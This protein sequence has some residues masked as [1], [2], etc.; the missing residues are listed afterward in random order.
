ML[1]A[2][3]QPGPCPTPADRYRN[4]ARDLLSGKVRALR[5]LDDGP[6]F[7]VVTPGDDVTAYANHGGVHVGD[8]FGEAQ[9]DHLLYNAI[10]LALSRNEGPQR[11]VIPTGRHRLTHMLSEADGIRSGISF[12]GCDPHAAQVFF[13]GTKPNGD[14]QHNGQMFYLE[15]GGL[16]NVWWRNLTLDFPAAVQNGSLS[17]YNSSIT[18]VNGIGCGADNCRFLAAFPGATAD[19]IYHQVQFIGGKGNLVRNC[20]ARASQV[21]LSSL[22]Y[23][24]DG[25]ECTDCAFEDCNDYGVS[26]VNGDAVGTFIRNVRIQR[27]TFRNMYGAGYIY[28]GSDAYTSENA[29]LTDLCIDD[30]VC[31]GN[32]LTQFAVGSRTGIRVSLGR[33]NLRIRVRRNDISNDNPEVSAP[34]VWGI[35]AN[36]RNGVSEWSEDLVF[37]DNSTDLRCADGNTL[38]GILI[39]ARNGKGVR[40]A[41]NT[42]RPGSRGL[43]V[44]DCSDLDVDRNRVYGATTHAFSIGAVQ[45]D[46]AGARMTGNLFQTVAAFKAA[47]AFNGDY[48]ISRAAVEDRNRLEA[49]G[50]GFSVLST[51]NGAR[52]WRYLR[53]SVN[54]PIG[55]ITAPIE[56]D[57]NELE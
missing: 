24:T 27:N 18:V 29:D 4:F 39:Q 12:D 30:N 10:K 11:L 38:E 17:P 31:S 40:V 21:R 14:P 7:D 43:R 57:G 46:I 47:V 54:R 53:N 1:E 32:I 26:C 48:G 19:G 15:Q 36:V 20:Y 22:G 25:N 49:A 51:G 5:L 52:S 37:E 2:Y 13:Q 55:A 56:D 9:G 16:E 34:Q 6:R 44:E 42:I 45:N 41:R 28:V 3:A 33:R 8:Y 50:N 35:A 23:S